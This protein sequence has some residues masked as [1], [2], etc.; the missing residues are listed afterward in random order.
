MPMQLQ[1]QPESRGTAKRN[2]TEEFGERMPC[3][4]DEGIFLAVL[5][6]HRVL[7]WAAPEVPYST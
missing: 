5:L 3:Q 2:Q 6:L 1:D 4:A 7:A